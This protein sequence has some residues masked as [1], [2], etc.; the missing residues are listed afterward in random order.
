MPRCK[1]S[2]EIKLNKNNAKVKRRE[3][4]LL[5]V[6]LF[7][8]LNHE[9]HYFCESSMFDVKNVLASGVICDEAAGCRVR[10]AGDVLLLF[11]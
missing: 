2:S 8:F 5:E 3:R 7:V 6:V 11:L 1:S 9:Q 10:G 4:L